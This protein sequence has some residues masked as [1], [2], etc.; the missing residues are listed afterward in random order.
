MAECHF[1][2]FADLFRFI[3]FLHSF[4]GD[5]FRFDDYLIRIQMCSLYYQLRSIKM[6]MRKV[7]M[8]WQ[9]CVNWT[10]VW[11]DVNTYQ[12]KWKRRRRKNVFGAVCRF[13][14]GVSAF[15]I[16]RRSDQLFFIHRLEGIACVWFWCINIFSTQSILFMLPFLAAFHAAALWW[17]M[18][19]TLWC[20]RAI[21][22]MTIDEVINLLLRIPETQWITLCFSFFFE[23]YFGFGH[24]LARRTFMWLYC[25]DIVWLWPWHASNAVHSFLMGFFF[26]RK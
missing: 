21:W 23:C 18:T 3:S 4:S 22:K 8:I 2:V 26:M 10:F 5:L 14:F 19:M 1:E 12:L 25:I 6:Q 13:F 9:I 24:C 11:S 15:L 17:V 20:A 7:A 16:G